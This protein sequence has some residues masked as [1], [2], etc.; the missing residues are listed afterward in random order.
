MCFVLLACKY[1][2]MHNYHRSDGMHSTSSLIYAS[3]CTLSPEV[4]AIHLQSHLCLLYT[5]PYIHVPQIEGVIRFQSSVLSLNVTEENFGGKVQGTGI[6]SIVIDL[7]Y[8]CALYK[9]SCVHMF[10]VH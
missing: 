8:E 9:K 7:K 5:F 10:T 2:N 6:L 4:N 3:E 1:G